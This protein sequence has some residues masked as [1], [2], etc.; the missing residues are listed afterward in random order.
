[1]TGNNFFALLLNL[2][3]IVDKKSNFGDDLN[4]F[5]F[6]VLQALFAWSAEG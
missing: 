3:D 4:H 2:L 1:M 5:A 6:R